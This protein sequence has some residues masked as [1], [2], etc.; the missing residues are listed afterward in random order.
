[1]GWG[2][3]LVIAQLAHNVAYSDIG[4]GAVLGSI[5]FTLH[6]VVGL[7]L[8]NFKRHVG[9]QKEVL[10]KPGINGNVKFQMS[11]FFSIASSCWLPLDLAGQFSPKSRLS[12]CLQNC[13]RSLVSS[14]S[15]WPSPSCPS[16]ARRVRRRRRRRRGICRCMSRGWK[17]TYKMVKQIRPHL[18]TIAL[19]PCSRRLLESSGLNPKIVL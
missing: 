5:A 7:S 1:M 14:S 11:R 9:T 3:W 15:T 10:V 12:L 4:L 17:E 13:S 18:M 19:H 6:V 8:I 2:T 16:A